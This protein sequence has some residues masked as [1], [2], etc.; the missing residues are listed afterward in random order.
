MILYYRII[1]EPNVVPIEIVFP[2][3]KY[4]LDVYRLTK[5]LINNQ[6]HHSENISLVLNYDTEIRAIYSLLFDVVIP[7]NSLLYVDGVVT[8]KR[9]FEYGALLKLEAKD[10]TR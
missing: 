1:L 6:T 4:G 7:E 3:E 2:P 5:V 10:K 8:D 9:Q